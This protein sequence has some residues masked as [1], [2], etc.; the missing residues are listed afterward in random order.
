MLTDS[1]YQ[2]GYTAHLLSHG[3]FCILAETDMDA[4]Y[5]AQ[6]LADLFKDI[7]IDVVPHEKKKKTLL[8]E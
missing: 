2:Y 1:N 8:S 4:A 7:L 6:Q 3:E 5:Q